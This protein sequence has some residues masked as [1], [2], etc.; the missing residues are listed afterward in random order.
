[1]FAIHDKSV[2]RDFNRH[3]LPALQDLAREA[4]RLGIWVD[5]WP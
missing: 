5:A 1:V 2:V 4:L 3:H